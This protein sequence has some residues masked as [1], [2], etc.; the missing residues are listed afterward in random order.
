MRC[1]CSCHRQHFKKQNKTKQRKTQKKTQC[2]HIPWHFMLKTCFVSSLIVN[3]V[4]YSP[5]VSS[6]LRVK[7]EQFSRAQCS[8]CRGFP[9]VFVSGNSLSASLHSSCSPRPALC[10][11]PLHLTTLD[12]GCGG[13]TALLAV[14]DIEQLCNP[15]PVFQQRKSLMEIF[16]H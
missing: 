7:A 14:P 5:P 13:F 10:L 8:D 9:L 4:T 15:T 16:T 6:W 3:V 11:P 2:F 1:V 12:M